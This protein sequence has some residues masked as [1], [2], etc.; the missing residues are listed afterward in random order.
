MY[1]LDSNL[2]YTVAALCDNIAEKRESLISEIQEMDG[3][4][5]FL[6]PKR[7]F[8]ILP[9]PRNG[10]IVAINM[11]KFRSDTLILLPNTKEV[12]NVQLEAFTSSVAYQLKTKLHGLLQDRNALRVA[13]RPLRRSPLARRPK[14]DPELAF[15]DILATLWKDASKLILDHITIMVSKIF[16]LSI[17][18]YSV[19]TG[20]HADPRV[21]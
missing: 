15:Q 2:P 6:H 14:G 7:I 10:V 21:P 12:V 5:D 8:D 13:K 18:R 1:P 4:W 16:N 17:P 19:L 3:F 9:S 11:S 20:Q